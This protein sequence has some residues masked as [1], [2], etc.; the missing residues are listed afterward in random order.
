MAVIFFLKF[1]LLRIN[2]IHLIWPC[3]IFLQEEK[4]NRHPNN[5]EK[6]TMQHKK[7]TDFIIWMETEVFP[8]ATIYIVHMAYLSSRIKSPS[9]EDCFPNIAIIC[10]FSIVMENKNEI[11]QLISCKY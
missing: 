10:L 1:S 8:I 6:E 2:V 9:I 5:I 4:Y 11:H 7:W 3:V